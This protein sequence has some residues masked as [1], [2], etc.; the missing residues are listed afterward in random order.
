VQISEI[1]EICART[2]FFGGKKSVKK[3]FFLCFSA[4]KWRAFFVNWSFFDD[5]WT[6]FG[7]FFPEIFAKKWN[8]PKFDKKMTKFAQI[9]P[10]FSLRNFFGEKRCFRSVAAYKSYKFYWIFVRKIPNFANLQNFGKFLCTFFA[11]FF[12]GGISGVFSL[13]PLLSDLQILQK[14]VQI[15]FF[16]KILQKKKC[17]LEWKTI[18]PDVPPEITWRVFSHFELFFRATLFLHFRR[19]STERK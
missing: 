14:K 17:F 18:A 8:S 2:F 12:P 7:H 13:F 3:C 11:L 4:G 16:C 1:S 19:I 6:K 15:L 10:E 5:F 9:F